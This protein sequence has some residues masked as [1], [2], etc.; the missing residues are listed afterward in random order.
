MHMSKILK[1]VGKIVKIINVQK[2]RFSLASFKKCEKS[3]N[4]NAKKQTVKNLKICDNVFN[5]LL[6]KNSDLFSNVSIVSCK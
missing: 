5:F 3:K 6:E 2:C 1:N 4:N